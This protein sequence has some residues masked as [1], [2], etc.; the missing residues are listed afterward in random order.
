MTP[1]YEYVDVLKQHCD[2]IIN[3]CILFLCCKFVFVLQFS[4]VL[5][6]ALYVLLYV[7]LCPSEQGRMAV[8]DCS[9]VK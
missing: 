3:D 4:C 9:E 7:A 1:F 8:A 5:S 6:L 2:S